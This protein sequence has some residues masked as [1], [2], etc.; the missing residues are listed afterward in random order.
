[1][2][3]GIVYL[4]QPV[5]LVF[6]K[7]ECYKVGASEGVD[8]EGCTKGYKNGTEYICVVRCENP[9]VLKSKIKEK[10]RESFE[11]PF[12]KEYFKGDIITGQ[13]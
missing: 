1:M 6:G 4:I 2:S 5:E 11:T 7:T 13:K 10:F 9:F 12:G 8:I 3:R